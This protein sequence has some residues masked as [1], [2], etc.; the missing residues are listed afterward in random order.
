[1]SEKLAIDPAR[2]S[3]AIGVARVICIMGIVYVHG[4]TG[5][6]GHELELARGSGQEIFRWT[7]MDMFGRSAVPLLGLISGWLVA[8]S[9][10]VQNWP[11]H[12]ARKARTILVPMILWNALAL[13]LICGSGWLFDLEIPTPPSLYWVIEEIFILTRT[14]NMNV[15]MPFLRDLFLCMTV[16][17]W[18]V[19]WPN[20]ALIAVLALSAIGH[21]FDLGAPVILRVSILFFFTLGI[22][23]RRGDLAARV[24]QWPLALAVL[25]FLLCLPVQIYLTQIIDWELGSAESRLLDLVVRLAAIFAY[26]RIAWA[27]TA[28]PLR[29]LLLKIEPFMFFYFCAHLILMWLG[30]PLLGQVFGK[31]GAPLYP[32]YLLAQ[33][34]LVLAVIMPVGMALRRYAPAAARILSGGR[35][36]RPRPENDARLAM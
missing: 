22:L 3:D 33:P 30:G 23:A 32:F 31:L 17:P 19:R 13:L 5:L 34:F 21:I 18:L 1:M 16:A 6:T 36:S 24:T 10:R 9:S 4:W 15:Q 28:S 27:L 7:L 35:L 8:G 29:T 14:P 2:R 12:V 11:H 26:W 25:P 20:R